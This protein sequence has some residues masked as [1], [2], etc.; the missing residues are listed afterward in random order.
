MS[1]SRVVVYSRV[2]M[3]AVGILIGSALANAAGVSDLISTP[4]ATSALIVI[5]HPMA[6]PYLLA[7]LIV[8]AR[9]AYG[10]SADALWDIVF[11]SFFA[12]FL[13]L[14]C[15]FVVRS[16]RMGPRRD[17]LYPASLVGVYVCVCE[18]IVLAVETVIR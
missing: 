11:L 6:L 18:Y 15:W 5:L 14:L 16:L 12:P 7:T 2:V 3:T 9:T 4:I 8:G 1:P 17:A 10:P 13:F